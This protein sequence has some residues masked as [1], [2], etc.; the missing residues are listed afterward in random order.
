[1]MW[2]KIVKDMRMKTQLEDELMGG[3]SR[4]IRIEDIL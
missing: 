4:D 3:G 1:M 2:I